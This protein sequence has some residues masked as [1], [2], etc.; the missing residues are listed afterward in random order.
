MGKTCMFT[1]VGIDYKCILNESIDCLLTV[2][3]ICSMI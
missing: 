2:E 1:Y 3:C